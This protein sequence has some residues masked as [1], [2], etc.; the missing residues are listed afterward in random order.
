MYDIAS[1]HSLQ[2]ITN[3]FVINQNNM[4]KKLGE[5]KYG[6]KLNLPAKKYAVKEKSLNGPGSSTED[7]NQDATL[8]IWDTN[9]FDQALGAVSDFITSGYD[10]IESNFLQQSSTDTLQFIDSSSRRPHPKKL[11]LKEKKASF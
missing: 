6:K 10:G 3:R 2:S 4:N 11:V 8:S 5:E 1:D 9:I 7:K